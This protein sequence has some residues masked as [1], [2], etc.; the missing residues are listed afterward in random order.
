[1]R[2]VIM[3]SSLQLI[4]LLIFF[5]AIPAG[6]SRPAQAKA[7][8]ASALIAAVNSLRASYGLPPYR[9]DNSLMTAAQGHSN[10]QAQIGT[11]THTGPGGSR[12]HDRAVAAGYGNGAQVYVSENVAMGVDLTPDQVVNKIWQ[13]AVHL[14]TMIS[15]SYQD[16]G[17][18][19]ASAGSYIFY[20][21]DVGYIAGSPGEGNQGSPPPTDI[22]GTPAPTQMA[23][24][25]IQIATPGP[26][27]SII[28]VVRW[29]QFLE[30]IAKAYNIPLAELLAL[31]GL[32]ADTVIY[33]GDKLLI[34]PGGNLT[35][36]AIREAA[37]GTP[38][39]NQKTTS[40]PTSLT[41]NQQ[42]ARTSAEKSPAIAMANDL[43]Q[44][45]G[46]QTQGNLKASLPRKHTDYLLIAVI[47]LAV[48]GFSLVL[49]GSTLKRSGM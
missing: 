2:V 27:G 26:D 21:I 31:N 36:T 47:S 42:A 28:H 3:R 9:V 4:V 48:S 13:D 38:Q 8:D 12:P 40:T 18:G 49:L 33:E 14:E 10:Y 6:I 46:E 16:I 7:G 23:M 20:T 34:R 41:V 17:A 5:L 30:N 22:N 11:W 19:V 35:P 39:T 25:P 44:P 45:S 15:S 37:S 43:A 29:G 24:V 1:M 32:S